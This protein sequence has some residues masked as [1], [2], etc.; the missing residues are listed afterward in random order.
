MK[1]VFFGLVV[2]FILIIIL[3]GITGCEN[4][5]EKQDGQNIAQNI[6]QNITNN[7]SISKIDEEKEIVYSI[8]DKSY[9]YTDKKVKVEIPAVNLDTEK[10]KEL[11]SEIEKKYEDAISTN[12]EFVSREVTY[13]YYVNEDI[14][15][16]VIKNSFLSGSYDTYMVYNI[17]SK[18]GEVLNNEDILKTKNIA[19]DEYEEKISKQISS[20]FEEN[21]STAKE[22]PGYEEAKSKNNSKENCSL[23]NTQVYLREDGKLSYIANVYAIAGADK[24]QNIFNYE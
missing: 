2:I 5:E 1:K 18:N 20:K 10:I 3:F 16:I 19:V 9:E 13:K 11:N 15:S 24:Y 12:E 7:P 6:Q 21:Y 17:D 8:I 23:D 14:I 4:K 22:M